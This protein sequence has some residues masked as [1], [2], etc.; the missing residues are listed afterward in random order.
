ME[1]KFYFSDYHIH[2][3]H[4]LR[5][6]LKMGYY[7]ETPGHNRGK[8]Q[9]IIE[10]FSAAFVSSPPQNLGEEA[11]ICVVDN[12]QFEAAAFC[13]DQSELEEFR[14]DRTGRPKTWLIM[15]RNLACELTGYKEQ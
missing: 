8:A 1:L 12:G 4:I 9:Y 6:E 13:Y 5:K 11:V 3:S 10:N 7:I 14:N 2:N 15:D